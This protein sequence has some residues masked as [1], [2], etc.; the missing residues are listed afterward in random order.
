M[1]VLIVTQG[2]L[3]SRYGGGQI[4]VLNLVTELVKHNPELFILSST[5]AKTYRLAHSKINIAGVDVTEFQLSYPVKQTKKDLTEK[6]RNILQKIQP[7]IVHA[8][9]LKEITTLAC[10]AEN[11]PCIITSHHGGIVCPQGA[12]L[13]H[14]DEICSIRA[15]DTDC[16]PCVLRNIRGGRHFYKYYRYL[17]L[18][19]RLFFGKIMA[20]LPFI[21]FMTPWFTTSIVIQKKAIEWENIHE[22]AALLI[23]PSEA[24]KTAMVRNGVEMGKVRVVCHGIPL[25]QKEP[26]TEG[27]FERPVRFIYIGRIN[28]VKGLHILLNAF[29]LLKGKAELTIIGGASTREEIRYQNRMKLEFK[30]LKIEW[31]G[32][33]SHNNISEHL[34]N[35]D[36]MVHPTICLE[37]YGLTIAE[38]LSVGRPVI[39]TRCGGPEMQ[40]E[41]NV[42]GYL[43]EPNNVEIFAERMQYLVDH[44]NEIIRLAANIK[45]PLSIE[46]HVNELLSLYQMFVNYK[47]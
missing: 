40:I 43:V 8:N 46:Q 47:A 41:N 22:K 29:M 14:L 45:Q 27:I 37:V 35:C 38:S 17:P 5:Q 30:N 2:A 15:N 25:H 44:P 32:N 39:A 7:D 12:L 18:G 42:N 28:R 31:T 24:I 13:N 36:V 20:K 33:L 1:K 23:A 4:Y 21:P 10:K 3:S 26:L 9:S 34:V 19:I 16:L 11:I 6:V